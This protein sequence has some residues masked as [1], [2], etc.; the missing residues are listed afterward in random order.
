MANT[1]IIIMIKALAEALFQSG[2]FDRIHGVVCRW[3]EK[4]ISGAE[5]QAGVLAELKIIGIE[6]AAWEAN[7]AIELA[8]AV[9]NKL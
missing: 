7:L 3:E 4:K 6:L 5:K 9:M 8:V 1:I 2:V